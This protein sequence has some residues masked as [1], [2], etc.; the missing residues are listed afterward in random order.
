M[1]HCLQLEVV[2]NVKKRHCR[3][4]EKKDEVQVHDWCSLG[5]VRAA[6]PPADFIQRKLSRVKYG[7]K[8]KRK[9]KNARSYIIKK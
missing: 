1:T 9:K 8:K 5:S 2:Y 4:I 7:P 6:P 3:T